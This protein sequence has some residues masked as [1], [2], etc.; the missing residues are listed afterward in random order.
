MDL[1]EMHAVVHGHVQG[2]GF[3]AT[4]REY[5]KQHHLY[6]T[7]CNLTDGTVEIYAQGTRSQLDDLIRY[8]RSIGGLG[9][10]DSISTE[11]TLPSELFE[12]F[13]ILRRSE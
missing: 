2:V 9:K 5:A 4:V 11:Y 12:H 3:R 7:V 1:I 13:I 8:L 10:V 6:G